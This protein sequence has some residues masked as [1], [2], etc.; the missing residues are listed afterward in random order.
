MSNCSHL[1]R[2]I[3][4]FK[5]SVTRLSCG[6]TYQTVQHFLDA[7]AITETDSADTKETSPNIAARMNCQDALAGAV[8]FGPVKV[9]EL[10]L[11]HRYGVSLYSLDE[12]NTSALHIATLNG[13][14]DAVQMLLDYGFDPNFIDDEGDAP[15]HAVARLHRCKGTDLPKDYG[16]M[17]SW[18]AV[19]LDHTTL[20]DLL[21]KHGVNP[22][23]LDENGN[24]Q[25]PMPIEEFREMI[26]E[27]VSD[28]SDRLA[29]VAYE[30]YLNCCMPLCIAA[31]LDCEGAVGLL[32]EHGANPSVKD[33]NGETPLHLTVRDNDCAI[34][35]RV[36]KKGASLKSRDCHGL[37]PVEGFAFWWSQDARM[38]IKSHGYAIG[39]L[40]TGTDASLTTFQN[41]EETV[42]LLLKRMADPIPKDSFGQIPLH[43]A[44]SLLGHVA[45]DAFEI[46]LEASSD[47]DSR[48]INGETP[49]YQAARAGFYGVL[50]MLLADSRA[51]FMA[52]NN[53]G[54]TALHL[55][56][57]SGRREKGDEMIREVRKAGIDCS[58]VNNDGQ[59]AM[60]IAEDTIIAL[61][62]ELT[63]E[64]DER[65]SE[66]SPQPS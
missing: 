7:A 65:E 45:E 10:L 19:F 18:I 56:V 61:A 9:V 25:E 49:L 22:D 66:E 15:I 34:A 59:T 33:P 60:D 50:R 24:P 53:H 36:I 14:S 52:K 55:A 20:V 26:H 43:M 4:S 38:V 47:T 42:R 5:I 51:D 41:C 57:L 40:G 37:T 46:L 62:C 3:H 31:F 17:S 6:V 12:V 21:L 23:G 29:R 44:C 2:F 30:G 54:N 13:S 16:F 1:W 8:G 48:D 27:K 32:L 35:E 64:S 39:I 58:M 63:E 11:N 28:F